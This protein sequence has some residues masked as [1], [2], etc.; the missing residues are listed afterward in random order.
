MEAE[1]VG[2]AQGEVEGVV[3]AAGVCLS[4]TILLQA[5]ML[6]LAGGSSGSGSRGGSSGGSGSRPGSRP[7]GGG[8][9][10]PDD[11]DDGGDSGAGGSYDEGS[12][13]TPLSDS[14]LPAIEQ[15]QEAFGPLEFSLN[16][17][18]TTNGGLFIEKIVEVILSSPTC[19]PTSSE[20]GV[21]VPKSIYQACTSKDIRCKSFPRPSIT[22]LT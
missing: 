17:T 18:N 2:G 9:G 12:Y 4:P 21:S 7:D 15:V 11:P 3:V 22:P 14:Y 8:S 16:S 13:Y 19:T 5:G 6:T 20:E 10:S 1:A